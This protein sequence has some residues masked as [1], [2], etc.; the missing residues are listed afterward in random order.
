MKES[1]KKKKRTTGEKKC[2]MIELNN[3]RYNPLDAQLEGGC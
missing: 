2:M 1:Q 3:R